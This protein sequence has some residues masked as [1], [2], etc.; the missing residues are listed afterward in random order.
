MMQ[1]QIGGWSIKYDAAL[2]KKAFD[3]IKRGDPERCGC[4]HCLN[5]IRIRKLVYPTEFLKLLKEL[6]IDYTKETEVNHLCQIKEGWHLYS[7]WFHFVGELISK[8]LDENGKIISYKY[9]G[10]DFSWFM[11]TQ[12][13]FAPKAFENQPLVQIDFETKAPWVLDTEEP[14]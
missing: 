13:L 12:K 9:Q 5:F 14:D 8:P 7:G 3:E 2:T 11:S 10:E 6:A 4:T 1:L